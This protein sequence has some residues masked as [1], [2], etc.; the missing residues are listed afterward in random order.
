M[1]VCM[2]VC[3]SSRIILI[4]VQIQPSMLYARKIVTTLEICE[5]EDKQHKSEWFTMILDK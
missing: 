4:W 5:V 3:M 2:Y 1:Y